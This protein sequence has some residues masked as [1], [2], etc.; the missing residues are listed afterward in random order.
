MALGA[1]GPKVIRLVLGQ[2]LRLTLVGVVIGALL[3]LG[4]GRLLASQLFGLNP[5][6]PLTFGVLIVVLGAVAAAASILPARRAA[7]VDPV[8]ALKGE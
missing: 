4:V 6:D 5:A 3:A 7:R 8:V 1:T 2:G